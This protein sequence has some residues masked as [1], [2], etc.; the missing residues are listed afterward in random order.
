MIA[1]E[2]F[3]EKIISTVL[4]KKVSSRCGLDFEFHLSSE[5]V[6]DKHSDRFRSAFDKKN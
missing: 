4:Q 5:H 3:N 1:D 6:H 2:W